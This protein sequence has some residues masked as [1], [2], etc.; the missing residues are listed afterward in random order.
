MVVRFLL[1]DGFAATTRWRRPPPAPPLYGGELAQQT[2]REIDFRWIANFQQACL[3][4]PEIAK[5]RLVSARLWCLLNLDIPIGKRQKRR[6][7][8][9]GGVPALV[10]TEREVTVGQACLHLGEL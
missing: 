3:A 5:C 6:P 9:P 4:L 8:R 1:R 7:V 2:R 10:L